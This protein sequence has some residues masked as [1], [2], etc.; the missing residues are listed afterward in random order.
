MDARGS[1]PRR[2]RSFF[3]TKSPSVNRMRA[4][5]VPSRVNGESSANSPYCLLFSRES[6]RRGRR[7]NSMRI[8]AQLPLPVTIFMGCPL[9]LGVACCM[10]VVRAGFPMSVMRSGMSTPLSTIS[11]MAMGSS[12]FMPNIPASRASL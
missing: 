10:V 7:E 6:S 4:N 1:K 12:I 5:L 11:L 3:R 2:Y 8:M 9:S